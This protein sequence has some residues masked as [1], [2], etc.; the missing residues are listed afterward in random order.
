MA[1]VDASTR[2]RTLLLTGTTL[3]TSVLLASCGTRL[4]DQAFSTVQV[5][6]DVVVTGTGTG[7]GTGTDL[8]PGPM[9]VDDASG[10]TTGADGSTGAAGA[11]PD[12]AADATAPGGAA[13][14][15]SG[16]RDVGTG[17]AG[18][19]S[20]GGGGGGREGGTTAGPARLPASDV[21]VTPS[22]IRLGTVVS[23]SGPVGSHAFVP[24]LLGV[25]AFFAQLNAR[26][27]LSGRKVDL[28]VCD[29]GQSGQGNEECVRSLITKSKVFALVGTSV[30]NYAG[31]PF[32][33]DAQVPDIGGQPVGRAYDTYPHLFSIYGSR[34]PRDGRPGY[35]GKL[36]GGTEDYRFFKEKLGVKKAAVVYYNQAAS[37]RFANATIEGLKR[38]GYDVVPEEV[39]F[40]LP[41]FDAAVVD[42]KSKG[43]DSV[44]DALD[45]QG[46]RNLCA[47][48][49][50]NGLR[51]K[52][53]VQTVQSWREAVRDY[54]APCRDSIYA[55]AKSRNYDQVS[56]PQVKAY[57]DAVQRYV[58]DKPDARAQWGLEGWV[59]AK[60]FTDAARSCGAQ[61]TRVCV[62]KFMNSIRNYTADG[63]VTARDFQPRNYGREKTIRNCVSVARWSS[64]AVRWVD[65]ADFGK[66]CYTTPLYSYDP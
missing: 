24:P 1:T 15:G 56:H 62:E 11:T 51:V 20:G 46:N 38:E 19:A 12:A 34:Y 21:G 25:Q 50:S 45:E 7:T 33:N 37:R 29:D 6:G 42:M 2:P 49:D 66:D 14:E 26:G 30:L 55:T 5:D 10:T 60:W 43:V 17:A 36:Y 44:W 32:V 4:P 31:A 13:P 63:L 65:V 54:N 22:T 8:G 3:V 64:K 57:R 61:L 39:S 27:G 52:A 16:G 48:M 35:Q 9:T 58:G 28:L 23:A 47:K 53:K 40:A 59:A 41:N 18:G